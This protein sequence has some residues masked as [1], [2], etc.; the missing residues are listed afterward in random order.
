MTNAISPISKKIHVP[1]RNKIAE[2][3]GKFQRCFM[4]FPA[5]A[6]III[7]YI[8]FK[9][10]NKRKEIAIPP[11]SFTKVTANH[12]NINIITIEIVN[13]RI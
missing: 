9:P 11:S 5:N 13:Q 1:I 6:P 7:E 2:I 12:G 10:K 8:G 3:T 4:S